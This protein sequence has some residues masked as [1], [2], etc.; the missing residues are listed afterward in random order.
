MSFDIDFQ[1]DA[2]GVNS[3]MVD[4][5]RMKFS[6][7]LR[8]LVSNA[9]KFTPRHGKVTVTSS[10]V[11]H[12]SKEDC[13][14]FADNLSDSSNMSTQASDCNSQTSSSSSSSKSELGPRSY[15]DMI[16]PKVCE[17]STRHAHGKSFVRITI[18]DTGSGINKVNL[19][20]HIY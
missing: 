16:D 17:G 4:I 5:D 1:V 9:L 20:N 6:Q 14:I 8:N 10:I 15:S 13:I 2:V 7:V 19:I 3:V 11:S 12:Y 18:K